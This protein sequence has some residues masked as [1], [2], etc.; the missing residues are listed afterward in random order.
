MNVLPNV[1]FYQHLMSDL[2]ADGAARGFRGMVEVLVVIW[3]SYMGV[4]GRWRM[5]DGGSCERRLIVVILIYL[6]SVVELV[7]VVV[8]VV[9]LGIWRDGRR[10][11]SGGIIYGDN[12]NSNDFR[13]RLIKFSVV[14]GDECGVD[15]W[16]NVR[17]CV[18]VCDHRGWCRIVSC[19]V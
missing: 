5:E 7:V 17:R 8:V 9:L 13:T 2:L 6:V 1:S 10:S 15:K 14:G 4:W 19:R 11:G 16:S 12:N 18:C 3:G